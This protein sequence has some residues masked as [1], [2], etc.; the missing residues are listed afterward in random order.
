M[1]AF[2]K[3]FVKL[4]PKRAAINVFLR[5][6]STGTEIPQYETLA[7]SVPKKNVFH[8][9]LNRPKKI[10]TFNLAMW[11]LV[12][13]SQNAEELSDV[14]RRAR[15]HTKFIKFAQDGI[16]A[17]EECYKP[18]ISVVHNACVGAGCP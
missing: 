4:Q 9:E 13:L 12:T 3:T 16:S 6:Y 14:A 17:L 7:V 5:A 11:D 1:A 10:N 18:V 8:V 15:F 2:V